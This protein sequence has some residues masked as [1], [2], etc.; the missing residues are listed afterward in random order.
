MPLFPRIDP[1]LR[2]LVAYI[3]ARALDRGVTLN[4]MRLV[5][6]L[7]LADVESVRSRRPALTGVEWIFFHYGPYAYELIDVLSAMESDE[8]ETSKWGGNVLYRAAPGAPDAHD[9]NA[10]TRRTVD[11]VVNRFA[12]LDLNELLDYVYFHTGPMINAERGRPLDL[13]RARDD[14][15]KTGQT[16]L[17]PPTRPVN[18]EQR[19]GAWRE[20]NARRLGPAVLDPPGR[21]LGDSADDVASQDTHGT[22]RVPGAVEL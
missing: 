19:L 17:H 6:L 16:P 15:A 11:R 21:F 20:R 3:V 22:L 5:K 4:R 8:L 10:G 12:P 7:Y 13:L 14:T 1:D 18:L 9:W 2:A